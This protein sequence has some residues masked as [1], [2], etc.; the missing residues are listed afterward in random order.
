MY[1][2]PTWPFGS[3]VRQYRVSI[4]APGAGIAE[5][6]QQLVVAIDTNG[7]SLKTSQAH[8]NVEGATKMYR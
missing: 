4:R 5:Y 1:D 3:H 7:L 6:N 2:S 8:L